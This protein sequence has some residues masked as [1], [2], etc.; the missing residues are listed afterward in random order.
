MKHSLQF[1]LFF[2]IVSASSSIARACFCIIDEVPESFKR[3][4][5]VFIGEVT[6]IAE[7]KTTDPDAPLPGRFYTI[8]FA[9]EK[10]WKGVPLVTKTL[11]V[12]SAQGHYGCF[13]YPPV[14]KGERYLVYADAPYDN[15][16]ENRSWNIIT[17]CNRTARIEFTLG[18]RDI[19]PFED[20]KIL[21]A[22]TAPP[23]FKLDFKPTWHW[24]P[25]D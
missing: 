3:A 14:Q 24:R 6:D 15:G 1:I 19:D 8:S 7:P 13:A 18:Q 5:A 25:L 10:S 17:F 21:N 23:S 9:V 4:N 12:L 2:A 22:I 16:T 11:T 20:M